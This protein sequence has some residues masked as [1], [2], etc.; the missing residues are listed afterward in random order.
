MIPPFLCLPQ[1]LWLRFSLAVYEIQSFSRNRSCPNF[2]R[3]FLHKY[4][5]F[6]DDPNTC[7]TGNN[8]KKGVGFC[9]QTC[10]QPFYG[11]HPRSYSWT[12]I[13]V[14]TWLL[15]HGLPIF[16][17]TS[18]KEKRSTASVHSSQ[19]IWLSNKQYNVMEWQCI[20]SLHRLCSSH[21]NS[22]SRFSGMFTKD[23]LCNYTEVFAK[24]CSQTVVHNAVLETPGNWIA[25]KNGFSG[26]IR[27]LYLLSSNASIHTLV[28]LC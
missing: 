3:T 26:D 19:A 11:Q 18:V 17:S 14:Y 21:W 13:S 15:L 22:S 24:P 28:F 10:S 5:I 16:L 9:P 25:F 1:D 4:S 8:R 2:S 20:C 7:C 23:K 12:L 27:Y 6:S